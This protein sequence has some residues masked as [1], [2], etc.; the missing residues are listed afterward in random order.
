MLYL[1][2][3]NRFWEGKKITANNDHNGPTQLIVAIVFFAILI[4]GLV[5]TWNYGII[6][7][8][9]PSSKTIVFSNATRSVIVND[10]QLQEKLFDI[11]VSYDKN[12]LIPPIS[13]IKPKVVSISVFFYFDTKEKIDIKNILLSSTNADISL[14]EPTPGGSFKKVRD[15][16]GRDIWKLDATVGHNLQVQDAVSKY[17][18]HVLYR[19]G[20]E[21]LSPVYQSIVPIEFDIKT[22]DFNALTYFWF[23]YI[24]VILSRLFSYSKSNN[25]MTL[26]LNKIDLLWVPFSAIITVIIFVSF[27][28]QIILKT[29]MFS[30]FALAFAFGFGFDKIF[31][32]LQ[33]R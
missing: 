24:G 33:K 32:T 14:V 27:K 22:M 26:K 8:Y 21:S 31:D 29:D 3:N 7:E 5:F 25:D 11:V 28:E 10:T 19:L 17:S 9:I 1:P 20:N 18:I 16:L 4:L 30:N 2:I 15:D 23:I 6:N 12:V 13:Y